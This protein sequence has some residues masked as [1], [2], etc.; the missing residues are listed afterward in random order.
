MEFS[1]YDRSLNRRRLDALERGAAQYLREAG[2]AGAARGM[3]R[4][5]ADDR[6]DLP[7]VGAVPGKARRV[8]RDRPRHARREHEHGDRGPARRPDARA[9]ADPRSASPAAP[10]VSAE[11][12]TLAA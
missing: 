5:A 6:D 12:A 4:L 11:A 7:L 9:R 2:R 8:G 3:V 1:G 10:G